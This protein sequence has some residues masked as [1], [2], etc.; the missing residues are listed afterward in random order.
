MSWKARIEHLR[1]A[2][3]ARFKGSCNTCGRQAGQGRAF[4]WIQPVD[5]DGGEPKQPSEALNTCEACK[6]PVD[7]GGA[8]LGV[9]G[10]DGL[11]HFKLFGWGDPLADE[12]G[13]VVLAPKPKRKPKHK[14]M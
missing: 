9:T 14:E 3:K 7:V 12:D 11:P 5:P 4:A 1:Q 13:N 2:L 8:A 10:A 6:G